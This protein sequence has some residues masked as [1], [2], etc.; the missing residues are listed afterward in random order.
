MGILRHWHKPRFCSP[1]HNSDLTSLLSNISGTVIMS[2]Q[3]DLIL[4]GGDIITME[5]HNVDPPRKTEAVAVSGDTILAVGTIDTV[6]RHAGPNTQII[7]LNQQTLMPGFIEPHQHA[8]QCALMRS[9]YTNI[10]GLNY[11]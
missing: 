2:A 9:Q 8:I 1:P 5:E 7:F 11:R 3:A 4:Y 10:S 6:F